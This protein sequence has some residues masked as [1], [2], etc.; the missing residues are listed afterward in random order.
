MISN[1]SWLLTV[2][3]LLFVISAQEI[4]GLGGFRGQ[5]AK[6]LEFYRPYDKFGHY[7]TLFWRPT[8]TLSDNVSNFFRSTRNF[9]FFWEIEKK[10]FAPLEISDFFGKLKK[11]NFAPLESSWSNKIKFWTSKV[12]LKYPLESPIYCQ[13]LDIFL[14][15]KWPISV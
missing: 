7:G 12:S 15:Q 13:T 8:E 9:R 10:N 6:N 1:N 4:H 11:K 2:V 5:Y 14:A 3:L